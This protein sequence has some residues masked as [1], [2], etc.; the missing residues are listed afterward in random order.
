MKIER[1]VVTGR[2]REVIKQY[3]SQEL[4]EYKFMAEQE[5]KEA[6][7]SWADAYVGFAPPQH[8]SLTGV[9]WVHSLGAGVDSFLFQKSWNEE[10]LLTRT[11]CSFGERI[12]QYCLSYILSDLQKHDE[13]RNQQQQYQ[14]LPATPL[15]LHTQTVIV[16][17]TGEIGRELA[18]VLS[19]LGVKVIGLSRSG[20]MQPYFHEV[21][22]MQRAREVLGRANWIISTL[23]LTNET[24]TMFDINFFQQLKSAGFMN[25]GRGR[26]VH[27]ESL[28]E[29]L[30]NGNVRKVVL[31]VF[32][33]EPLPQNS[34]LWHHPNVVVTPHISAVTT[35]Q[36]AAQCF[37][38]TLREIEEGKLPTNI[39]D[40]Q[41]G[42]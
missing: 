16:Y 25:V 38:K 17:G 18:R 24:E 11:I 12:A 15:L 29:A 42:Y 2:L 36:E 14:W 26:T 13:F 4:Y 37:L 31:D 23:P 32:E 1:I 41:K 28:V 7:L 21:L 10:V 19:Y 33:Q 3:L 8:T 20:Q 30:M 6:D 39:V 34:Q 27:E 22:P 9:K 40:P 35:P 5:V